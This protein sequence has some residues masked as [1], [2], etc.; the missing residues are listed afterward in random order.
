MRMANKAIQRECHP[1]PTIDDLI[2]VLNGAKVFSKLDLRSGYHQLM[3]AEESR[4]ITTFATHKG[5]RR[6]GKPNFGACSASEIFQHIIHEQIR[7]IPNVLN[8]SN[9]VIVFG[10]TQAEH[11]Y[12]LRA[13]FQRF[14]DNGLTL[15]RA[16]CKF[17]QDQ[18]NFVGF[19][20]S[21]NGISPDP[22]KVD[23]I[24][25]APP[26]STVKDVRSFIGLVTYCSK[27]IHNSSDLS[28]PL[29]ELTK[30]KMSFKWTSEDHKSFQVIKSALTSTTVMAYF[31]KGKATQLITDASPTGLSAILSQMTPHQDDRTIVAYI[32]RALTNVEQRCL[33]TEQEALVI[34]WAME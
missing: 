23:A 12:T 32:N 28:Q 22:L 29:Q 8:I 18:L 16:K 14:S 5:L 2:H 9:D 33:Q 20:F 27:F 31:D 19:M 4:Y 6:Y 1:T 15:N 24:K 11:D 25:N 34:V 3:L 10:T 30:K 13:V 7:D 17:N 21:G 26:P